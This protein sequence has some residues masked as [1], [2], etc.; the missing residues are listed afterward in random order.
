MF[1]LGVMPSFRKINSFV[2]RNVDVD[3]IKGKKGR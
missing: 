2:N 3:E 1:G